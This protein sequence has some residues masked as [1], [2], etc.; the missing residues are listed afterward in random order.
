MSEAK[1]TVTTGGMPG[2]VLK[3]AG[4]TEARGD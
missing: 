1:A 3:S 4:R 2:V